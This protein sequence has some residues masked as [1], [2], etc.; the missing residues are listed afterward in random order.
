MSRSIR[1]AF[2]SPRRELR[3]IVRRC[4]R[5]RD[6]PTFSLG[7]WAS[8]QPALL[9]VLGNVPDS[10]VLE[11]GMGYAST[12]IVLGLSRSSV[13]L[14]TDA[15]WFARFARFATAEHAILLHSD[16]TESEWRT[17]YLE[18][19]WDV[20]FIDNSPNASRQSNLHKLAD[21]S[22]F[23]VCHDTEELFRPVKPVYGWDFSS[24]RYVWTYPHFKN[25]TTVLSNVEPIPHGSLPG[26]AGL[27]ESPT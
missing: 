22:R 18:Q 19:D 5:A 27:P 11:L 16:Y 24:F 20:V 4:D 26:I 6:D 9:E 15:G 1:E 17:P 7:G 8:H 3:R 13:S 14:E 21:R 2:Y 10:R 12:P 25:R 23:I